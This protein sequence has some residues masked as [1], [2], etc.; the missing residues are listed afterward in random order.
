M[1]CKGNRDSTGEAESSRERERPDPVEREALV[2]AQLMRRKQKPNES[3]DEFAQDLEKL[4][5][6]SCGHKK[7]MD[8]SSKE[9]LKR[10]FLCKVCG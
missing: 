7:G 10:D 3:V 2:S 5:E 9:M 4:F 6:H 8:E 1:L